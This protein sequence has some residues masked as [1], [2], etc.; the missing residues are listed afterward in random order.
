MAALVESS[1]R[2]G[3]ATA[4]PPAALRRIARE[5]AGTGRH[6]LGLPGLIPVTTLAR[7]VRRGLLASWLR[8]GRHRRAG[9]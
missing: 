6:R 1:A 4:I 3:V 2:P 5:D 9:W 8:R 7:V